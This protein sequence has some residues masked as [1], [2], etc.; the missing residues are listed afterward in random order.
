GYA[1]VK[2]VMAQ[3]RL[4]PDDPSVRGITRAIPVVAA[5]TPVADVLE[6]LTRDSTHIALVRDGAGRVAGMVTLED[7]IEELVGDIEDEFDRLPTHVVPSG[8]GWVVGGG[9]TPAVLKQATGIELPVR[10]EAPARHLSEWVASRRPDGLR[11]G[12]VIEEDGVR[13]AVRKVRRQK[14]QEAQVHKRPVP[15]V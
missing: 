2:D 11:G 10:P 13:V 4:A 5:E 12:D 8:H 14:V 6:R 15:G 9:V 1:N 7:I 3:M